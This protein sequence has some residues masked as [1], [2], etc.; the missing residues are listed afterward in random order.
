MAAT[1]PLANPAYSARTPGLLRRAIFLVSMPFF[2][3]GLLLP[4]Y[5]KQIGASVVE[6]GLFFS[7]FSLVTVLLRPLAGWRTGS[8]AS[9]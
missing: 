4:V 5:G 1:D 8:A 9:R 3:L 7:V 6:I 2:M